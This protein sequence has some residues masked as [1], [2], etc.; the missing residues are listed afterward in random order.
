[1][2]KFEKTSNF[3]INFKKDSFSTFSWVCHGN[4]RYAKFGQ[5][6]HQEPSGFNLAD[7]TDIR[8]LQLNNFSYGYI[9]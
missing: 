9:F 1:M 8:L 6:S 7:K 4:A 5:M 2:K 3:L